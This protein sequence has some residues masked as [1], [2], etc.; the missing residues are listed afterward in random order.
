MTPSALPARNLLSLQIGISCD[1]QGAG[2]S[3]RIFSD[4][5]R[6]L[7][8]H[9]ID[10]IGAVHRPSDIVDRTA[11]KIRSFAPGD[12]DSIQR[13]LS[14]RSTIKSLIEQSDPDLIV[15]HFAFYTIPVLEELRR[16]KLVV[17]FHGPW[18]AES[19]Q[20]GGRRFVSAVKAQIE[21]AVYS[22]ALTVIV[23][24]RAFADLIQSSY[25]IPASRIRIIPG[26]VDIARFAVPLSR[27]EARHQLGWPT[28][29]R[30]L[31]TVR[32]LVSRMGLENLIAAVS[33]L[34]PRYPDLLLYV[35]GKGRLRA[36]LDAQAVAAGLAE[37][38]RFLGYVPEDQ[39][40]LAYRA[41][42]YNVVPTL[43]LEGFGMVAIEALAAG[44]PSLV[45]PVGG[46]PE[47]VSDLSADMIFASSSPEDLASGLSGVLSGSVQLPTS[48]ECQAY[49]RARFG[50]ER[51]VSEVADVYREACE[52]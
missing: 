13:L 40:P 27:A 2:G 49:A 51:M 15:S 12:G 35:A 3:G 33:Q 9:G 50:V 4:L 30:I 31:L 22:K 43:S 21:H 8:E 19:A 39:L 42:D 29:R 26:A 46:L 47:T 16:R 5:V 34:V 7:P 38:V 48:E 6:Y 18:A 44:T 36:D 28:D 11:G 52:R 41:A 25:K 37:H 23:L 32:R 14:A 24:S 17:H 45:T 1:T 10:V 20:E